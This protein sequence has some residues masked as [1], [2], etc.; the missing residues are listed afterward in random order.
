MGD[1]AMN[2]TVNINLSAGDEAAYGAIAAPADR[3]TFLV[4]KL[5]AQMA[6]AMLTTLQSGVSIVAMLQPADQAAINSLIAAVQAMP[7]V[8][9]PTG[10]GQ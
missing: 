4:A 5:A 6:P 7:P 8:T 10:G 3:T 2:V 9:P 1:N